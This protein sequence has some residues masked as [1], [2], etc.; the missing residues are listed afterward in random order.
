MSKTRTCLKVSRVSDEPGHI[1]VLFQAGKAGIR[2]QIDRSYNQHQCMILLCYSS[3]APIIST[4]ETQT[5][6]P[7][8]S[9][10]CAAQVEFLD[11]KITRLI[12]AGVLERCIARDIS[13]HVVLQIFE[14]QEGRTRLVAWREATDDS[15]MDLYL[16]ADPGL[17]HELLSAEFAEGVKDSA[18]DHIGQSSKTSLGLYLVIVS[19]LHANAS[20]PVVPC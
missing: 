5:G 19:S 4:Y 9:K 7:K 1:L 6:C 16:V 11:I 12:A 3:T 15:T 10:F 14:R 2:R 18:R 13:T 17:F 8:S 20:A